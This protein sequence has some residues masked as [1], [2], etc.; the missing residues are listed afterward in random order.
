[1]ISNCQLTYDSNHIPWQFN[2]S[3]PT[4]TLRLPDNL[5]AIPFPVGAVKPRSAKP[6]RAVCR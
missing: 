1:M 3:D 6:W 2:L 4:D 5:P